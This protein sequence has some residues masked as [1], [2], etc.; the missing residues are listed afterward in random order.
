[1]VTDEDIQTGAS[2]E[3]GGEVVVAQYVMQAIEMLTVNG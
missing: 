3:R 2:V 1:M